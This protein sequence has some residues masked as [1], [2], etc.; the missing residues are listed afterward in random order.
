MNERSRMIEL[1]G[2]LESIGFGF[3][4]RGKKENNWN[5]YR[6]SGTIRGIF[7]REA[8][9]FNARRESGCVFSL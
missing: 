6:V 8:L 3:N 5:R 9:A 4:E 7:R 2:D 1:V